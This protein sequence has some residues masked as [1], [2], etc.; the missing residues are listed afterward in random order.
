MA[1]IGLTLLVATSG[2]ALA[3]TVKITDPIPSRPVTSIGETFF[4]TDVLFNYIRG[5]ILLSA[6]KNGTGDISVDDEIVMT[7]TH[8]DGSTSVYQYD[9][10]RGCSGRIIPISP[11]DVSTYFASGLNS[12]H[13]S[14]SLWLVS[15]T[16]SFLTVSTDK[17]NYSLG[18]TIKVTI[19][20]NRSEAYPQVA[21]FRL[22]L[23]EPYDT[24][25]TLIETV[26]IRLDL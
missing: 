22:Q 15:N 11:V 13:V 16:T 10:S 2:T 7:I 8:P 20:V 9:F 21:K 1:V 23:K 12:V 25:D 17:L 24:P 4:T 18:E 3:D 19:E 5:P 14:S 6:Y 26:W